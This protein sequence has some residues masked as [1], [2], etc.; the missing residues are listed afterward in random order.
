VP[1]LLKIIKDRDCPGAP[2]VRLIAIEALGEIG[3]GAKEAVPVL[4]DLLKED[5]G[6]VRLQAAASLWRITGRQAAARP[7]LMATLQ[8][9][10]AEGRALAAQTLGEIGPEAKEAVPVLVR[11]AKDRRAGLER[12]AAALA[13]WR[14]A[15]HASAVPALVECIKGRDEAVRH[16]ASVDLGR[17][18][19][20]AKAAVSALTDNLEA[21]EAVAAAALGEIGPEARAAV[22][23]L[24]KARTSRNAILRVDAALALWRIE[25]AEAALA[26]WRE[27]FKDKQ[28]HIRIRSAEAL[29]RV[30]EGAKGTVPA[31]IEALADRSLLVQDAAGEAL[32]K[33]D[34]EAARKAGVQ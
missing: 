20:G 10:R 23:A 26:T 19:P 33:I 17:L 28:K 29:A 15:R 31:L 13:L 3:P 18:G 34:P 7:V 21:G 22:P 1:G 5:D 11:I 12:P 2:R 27:A 16:N 24:H 25:K 6:L 32:K 9:E 4:T 14:I 30:G 8:D